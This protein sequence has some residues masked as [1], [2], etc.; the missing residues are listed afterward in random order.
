MSTIWTNHLNQ[1]VT[2]IR[3]LTHDFQSL[4]SS[5]SSSTTTLSL[6]LL[7]APAF[8][9]SATTRATLLRQSKLLTTTFPE[10]WIT[11]INR[12]HHASLETNPKACQTNVAPRKTVAG[13]DAATVHA[14][15]QADYQLDT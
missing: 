12:L 6:L 11:W 13:I 9:A 8:A 5:S 4:L 14:T 10:R 1:I 7:R 2:V 15:R 3:L